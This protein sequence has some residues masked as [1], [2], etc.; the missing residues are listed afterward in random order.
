MYFTTIKKK[1]NQLQDPQGLRRMLH[2]P[3]NSI[4]LACPEI[5]KVDIFASNIQGLAPGSQAPPAA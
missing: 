4:S 5:W 1:N 2:C 3:R